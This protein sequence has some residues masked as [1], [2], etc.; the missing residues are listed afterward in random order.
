MRKSS[1]FATAGVP[2]PLCGSEARSFSADAKLQPSPKGDP[3]SR[4]RN[5]DDPK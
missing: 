4:L 2:N 5:D 3:A 1:M